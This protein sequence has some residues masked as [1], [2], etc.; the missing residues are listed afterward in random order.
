M[1]SVRTGAVA[2]PDPWGGETLEWATTS[3]PPPYNFLEIPTVRS[4]EPVWDQP[5]L[6]DTGHAVHGRQP[7]LVGHETLGTSVMDAD[8]ESV[9]PMPHGSYVPVATA[10]GLAGIFAGLLTGIVAVTAI[11][12]GIA[13]TATLFWFRVREEEEP[14]PSVVVGVAP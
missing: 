4:A 7:V 1:K 13:V 5:E 3:P 10:C 2:G 12:V 14:G 11:A 8:A 9:I 6:R